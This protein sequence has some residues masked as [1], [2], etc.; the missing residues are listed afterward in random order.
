MG[1]GGFCRFWG[2]KGLGFFGAGD[3]VCVCACNVFAL[4]RRSA[5]TLQKTAHPFQV[6]LL[7][8]FLLSGL[9]ISL[10]FLSVL[11]GT[12]SWTVCSTQILHVFK[13]RRAYWNFLVILSVNTIIIL[14]KRK[15]R[16]YVSWG[17]TERHHIF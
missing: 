17:V 15:Q 7:Q 13:Q 9:Q 12:R 8:S 1:F 3:R 16:R 10:R 14:T 5:D 2:L 4:P 6:F 11:I